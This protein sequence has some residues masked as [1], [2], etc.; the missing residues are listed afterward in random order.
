MLIAMVMIAPGVMAAWCH[1]KWVSTPLNTADYLIHAIL[2]AF[3]IM[4]FSMGIVCLRGYGS[5]APLEVFASLHSTL[6]YCAVATAAAVAM[7]N[8]VAPVV[9][10]LRR[11]NKNAE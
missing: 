2:Y 10:K 1:C 7:P 6:K 3:F 11:G 8:I 9:I 5:I 4:V